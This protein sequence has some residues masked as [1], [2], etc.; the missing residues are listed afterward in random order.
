MSSV[1][2]YVLPLSLGWA[3]PAFV[4]EAKKEGGRLSGAA[5]APAPVFDAMRR[6]CASQM[7][8]FGGGFRL[9]RSALLA[10]VATCYARHSTSTDT[11]RI[12]QHLG[13]EPCPGLLRRTLP[14]DREKLFP[15]PLKALK[16]PLVV[17]AVG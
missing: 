8:R 16:L 9:D 13:D 4:S 12:A 17:D 5:L 7:L 11:F 6:P 10:G 1:Y 15:T 3:M 14:V 2:K